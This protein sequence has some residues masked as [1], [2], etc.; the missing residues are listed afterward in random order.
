MIIVLAIQCIDWSDLR[1]CRSAK[2]RLPLVN[3]DQHEVH[4]SMAPC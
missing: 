4:Q 3:T 1:D 2:H